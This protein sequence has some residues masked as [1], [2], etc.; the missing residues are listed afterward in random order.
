MIHFVY[1][2]VDTRKGFTG[3]GRYIVLSS[4]KEGYKNAKPKAVNLT[5]IVAAARKLAPEFDVRKHIIYEKK[6]IPTEV[7]AG[8]SSG[9]AYLLV[10]ISGFRKVKRATSH[11]IWCTGS[12]G[13]S[14]DRTP[15]LEAI[16]EFDVKL[17]EFLSEKNKDTLFIVPEAN[18]HSEYVAL[19]RE[20]DAN[21]VLITEFQNVSAQAIS[22][23]KTVLMVC[24]DELQELVDWIFEQ[25][26]NS[27]TSTNEVHG[28]SLIPRTWQYQVGDKVGAVAIDVEGKTIAVGTP[29]KKVLCLDAKGHLRW[30]KNVGKESYCIALSPD[31]QTIVVG[32]W[33]RFPQDVT[34]CSLFCFATADGSLRWQN[35]SKA[36]VWGLAFSADGQTVAAGTSEELVLFDLEGK[37][38]TLQDN[39]AMV[40]LLN[41]WT[42][43][44]ALS[45]TGEIV[46][47]GTA[48]DKR[49]RIFKR[50]GALLGEYR[51]Q[52]DL[53]T[54]AVSANGEFVATGD[55]EG[56][57][58]WL[59]QQGE[60]LWKEHLADKIQA[61]ALDS[62]AQQL[63]VGTDKK[64]GHLRV[65]DSMGRLMWRHHVGGKVRSLALSKNGQRAVVGTE[66]GNVYIFNREGTVLHQTSA[67]KTVHSVA[68]SATGERIVAG[69]LDGVI[70]GFQLQQCNGC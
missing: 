70:Y 61:V 1:P 62:D 66:E 10:L 27:E 68:I 6:D 44:V 64:D 3:C 32:T 69:S 5:T 31:G 12:I 36:S 13:F 50:N 16:D 46:A 60:L 63:W 33:N 9:L 22:E 25:P 56:Y 49:M 20:K 42:M 51:T 21:L 39:K 15:I 67:G 53:Y 14:N 52:G 45:A 18:T 11:D 40:W 47:A 35:V 41:K 65:Y 2:N 43:T 19:C 28:E 23:Q 38:T 17:G 4:L 55:T 8:P 57:I 24:E 54:V 26:A 37:R 29:G 59:N 7:Y 58:Y 48:S 30:Q 34:K